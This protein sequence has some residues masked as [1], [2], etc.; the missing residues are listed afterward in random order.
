MLADSF[1]R[2]WRWGVATPGSRH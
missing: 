2:A 1:R